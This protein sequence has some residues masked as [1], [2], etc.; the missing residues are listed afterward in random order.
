MRV[1]NLSWRKFALVIALVAGACSS[2]T[3]G[4]NDAA[5]GSSGGGASAGKG[6]SGG[7]AGTTGAGGTTGS[8]GVSGTAGRGG[9]TGSAGNSGGGGTGGAGAAMGT[10][11]IG[12]V[13]ANTSN[14]S[15]ADGPAVC[16]PQISTCVLDG[17]CPGSTNYVPCNDTTMPCTKAGWICCHSA[18]MTY[19]TKQNGC[20]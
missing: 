3:S 15:Q 5:A 18:S 12:S 14:C 8:A 20:L 1:M 9:A 6:G 16:C 17:Q 10:I 2:S 11:P 13:C 7:S 4:G 19:C